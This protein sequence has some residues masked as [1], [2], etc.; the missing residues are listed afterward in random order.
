MAG[1]FGYDREHFEV[2][3]AIA[4]RALIPAIDSAP[5][6]A[7]IVADGFS[8]RSQIRHFCPARRPMHLAQLLNLATSRPGER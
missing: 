7:I 3:R 5:N 1:A 6:D 2:S 8:C 4:M